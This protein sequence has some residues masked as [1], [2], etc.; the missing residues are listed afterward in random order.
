VEP[1]GSLSASERGLVGCLV[2][3]SEDGFE[4]TVMRGLKKRGLERTQFACLLSTP[5][6]NRS[7]A[8]RVSVERGARVTRPFS[9]L[10]GGEGG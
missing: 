1:E 5:S 3:Y 4:D 9:R 6:L 7:F 8:L 2:L 10:R